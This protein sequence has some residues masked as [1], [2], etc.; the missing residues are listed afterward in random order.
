VS[1]PQ[2]DADLITENRELRER[3]QGALADLDAERRKNQ[4]AAEAHARLDLK[5]QR[6]TNELRTATEKLSRAGIR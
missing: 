6:L 2:Q 5:L 4:R 1:Y 3:L